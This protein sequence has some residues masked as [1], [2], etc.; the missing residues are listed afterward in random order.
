MAKKISN[1][2]FQEAAERQEKVIQKVLDVKAKEEDGY[3]GFTDEKVKLI[4]TP[5]FTSA[6]SVGTLL[7]INMANEIVVDLSQNVN[8]TTG[9]VTMSI[10]VP[11]SG[12]NVTQSWFN[13]TTTTATLTASFIANLDILMNGLE[14]SIK[15]KDD[16]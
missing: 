10:V 15:K 11:E 4:P 16:W 14:N 5:N 3:D 8:N 12:I 13:P 6:S 1:E 2:V 9:S 7:P